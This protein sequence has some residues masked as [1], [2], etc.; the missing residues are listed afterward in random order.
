MY[1]QYMLMINQDSKFRPIQSLFPFVIK[2]SGRVAN[3]RPAFTVKNIVSCHE[4]CFNLE[5]WSKIVMWLNH[6]P[7][8]RS[9]TIFSG[10]L[11][12]RIAGSL[13]CTTSSQ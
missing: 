5:I 11:H 8:P 4:F 1:L 7:F 12:I 10:F 13:F 2:I 9:F 6:D 3:F